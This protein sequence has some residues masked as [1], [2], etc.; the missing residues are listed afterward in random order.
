VAEFWIRQATV[1][2]TF[3]PTAFNLL[4]LSIVH[5]QDPWRKTIWRSRWILA[6][7]V[8]LGCF[9][10]THF[11]LRRVEL[12]PAH[13]RGDAVAEPV[14]GPGWAV[15]LV[16]F[17][18]F[19]VWLIVRFARDA[20]RASGIQRTELTFML[21]ACYASIATGAL[22]GALVP[23]V[24]GSSQT[25]PFMPLGVIVMTGIIAY[26]VATKRLLEVGYVVRRATAFA[27]LVLYLVLL[28]TGIYKG[29]S[30]A[31][32]HAPVGSTMVP[33]LLA[34]LAVAFTMAPAH[35]RMQQIVTRLFGGD[36]YPDLRE[37]VRRAGRAMQTVTTQ[38]ELLGMFSRIVAETLG[39]DRVL[40]LVPDGR[41]GYE[42]AYPE[43]GEGK[44]L[45]LE[46]SD[47]LIRA[48]EAEHDPL[49]LDS[50][51]RRRQTPVIQG[52][53]HS[54]RGHEAAIAAGIFLHRS[55]RGLLLLGPRLTGRIY[56]ALEQELLQLLG[57][58]FGVALE[59]AR[60]YT[61]V[62]ESKRYNDFLVD[63]LVSGVIAVNADRVVT[64]FNQEAERISGLV[65]DRVVGRA[66]EALP[67]AIAAQ[68]A[69][70]LDRH[71]EVIDRDLAI[72]REDG[73][74]VPI[75]LSC[76]VFRGQEGLLLGALTV[77]NDMTVL[78]KLEEQVRRNDRLSSI[79]TL[80]AGMA[81]EI[82]NPLVSIKTFT[83]LLPERYQ[84][85]E[86]RDTF[87]DL[88][89]QEVHRIDS[90]VNRLLKFS[91]P[92][93]ANLQQMHLH[94]AVED[95]LKLV[96]QQFHRRGIELVCRLEAG[97][98]DIMGDADLLNQALVNF[99]LNA[100]EAMSGG[101]RLEVSTALTDLPRRFVRGRQDRNGSLLCLSIRDSGCGISQE[102][103]NRVFDP[104]FTTKSSGTGLG[105][106][107][108]HG[109]IDEHHATVEVESEPEK[110]TAFH[111]QFPLVNG[112]EME[113]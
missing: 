82:K 35:G 83:Q 14:Y 79:G 95:S 105:L 29:S 101:G 23:L 65:A 103:I 15:F 91:R 32:Y 47:P 85:T 40:I 20:R 12:A 63:S 3:V 59:N 70:T 107:V 69:E 113:T 9:Y 8:G 104:F 4:R 51:Q 49:D 96:S 18:G 92:A 44:G 72:E 81:H 24:T 21:L 78:R 89:G 88:I 76:S 19:L 41:E 55:L 97:Q 17:I 98:D 109:I 87:F 90:L 99:F 108:A 60:L 73:E 102:D 67:D 66:L 52:A 10:Q 77:F 53:I 13:L 27:L 33:Q 84:D 80:A 1:F 111:I 100:M 58:Q 61:E 5:R 30:L 2:A 57:N 64:V 22:L 36:K 56:G 7:N 54:L 38:D 28:Y 93:R 110:G 50:L 34:A 62:R 46:A 43:V 86:F 25:A 106:A 42:Q 16:Y 11:F 26:G 68:L 37:V 31:L 45:R 48:L 6:L 112:K 74:T 39:A 75:R 71:E 94:R